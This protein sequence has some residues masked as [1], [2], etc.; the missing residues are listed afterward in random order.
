M[1]HKKKYNSYF[2][3]HY[4]ITKSGTIYQMHS[5]EELTAHALGYNNLAISV[6]LQGN[7]DVEKLEQKQYNSLIRALIM[8]KRKY[9]S[10]S[11]IGHCDVSNKTCPGVNINV[12][13]LSDMV[14][15]FHILKLEK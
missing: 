7:F 2:S 11:I 8:V 14:E 4:Y 10:A 13:E 9:P 5:D 6:C 12:K 1:Y 3:Y 15:G